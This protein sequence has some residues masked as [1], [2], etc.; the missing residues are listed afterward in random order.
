MQFGESEL[1]TDLTQEAFT[2]VI[3]ASER[4]PDGEGFRPWLWTIAINLAH[5]QRRRRVAAPPTFSIH[6][7]EP[8]QP[9]LE[10]VLPDLAPT[11]RERAST[12]ERARRLRAAIDLLEE[13]HREVILLKYFQN[14]P[15]RDVAQV[16]GVTEG[17]VWS[18]THRALT[19]L[20]ALLAPEGGESE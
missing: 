18:R 8:E 5:S 6:A 2:R 17:T 16:L 15:C 14:L 1:A 3:G 20:R 13:P 10:E 9:S 12:E 19:Q 4:L 7:S 11:P